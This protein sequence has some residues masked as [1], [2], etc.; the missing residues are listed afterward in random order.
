V[1]RILV[2]CTL[3]NVNGLSQCFDTFS[4]H[5]NE[6]MGSTAMGTLNSFLP[7]EMVVTGAC[8]LY[9]SSHIS[10]ECSSSE[11]RLAESPNRSSEVHGVGSRQ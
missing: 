11:R 7:S 4:A 10:C 6:S 3:P 9:G 2:A 8:T 1:Y 5:T